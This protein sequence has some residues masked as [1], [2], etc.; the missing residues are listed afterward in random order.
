MQATFLQAPFLRFLW[1][2][3]FYESCDSNFFT[4]AFLDVRRVFLVPSKCVE[5]NL[6]PFWS[7]LRWKSPKKRKKLRSFETLQ[8]VSFFHFFRKFSFQ[9]TPDLWKII[10][11]KL[12][13]Y[14]K[15]SSNIK[16]CVGKKFRV[17]RLVE[18]KMKSKNGI[19][20]PKTSQLQSSVSKWVFVLF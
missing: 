10:F 1:F 18:M 5:H 19:T 4:D 12:W 17:I 7:R 8:N 11:N 9:M 6:P 14:L 13:R 20:P 15:H 3:H 2:F 16:E